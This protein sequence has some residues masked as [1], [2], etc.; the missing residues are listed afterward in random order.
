MLN[1]DSLKQIMATI[2]KIDPELIQPDASM[3]TLSS[4]DS[5]RHINLILALEEEFNVLIPDE[6][7]GKIT[8]YPLIKLVLSDLLKS[9]G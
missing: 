6:E 3:D 4:W 1:E 2:L 5:L 7:A 9:Q 8:S